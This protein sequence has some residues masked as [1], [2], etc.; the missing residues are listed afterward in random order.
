MSPPPPRSLVEK[1]NEEKEV[2]RVNEPMMHGANWPQPRVVRH[3]QI[4]HKAPI[5]EH[6]S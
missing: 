6:P 5:K 4:A 3:V 2:G 1:W